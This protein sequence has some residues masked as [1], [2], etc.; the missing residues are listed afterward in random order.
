MWTH[1]DVLSY[2]RL[3]DKILWSNEREFQ[4]SITQ[5]QTV[6]LECLQ[7]YASQSTRYIHIGDLVNNDILWY[8]RAKCSNLKY[9]KLTKV[10][11]TK[12]PHAT[13]CSLPRNLQIIC[14]RLLTFHGKERSNVIVSSHLQDFVVEPFLLLRHLCLDGAHIS[15]EFCEQLCISEELTTL[16]L[17]SCV[18]D[19]NTTDAFDNLTRTLKKLKRVDLAF[20]NF[21]DTYILEQILRSIALNLTNCEQYSFHCLQRANG[22]KFDEFLRLVSTNRSLRGLKLSAIQGITPDVF[23]DFL[24]QNPDIESLHLRFCRTVND[25]T[26]RSVVKHLRHLKELKLSGC[27][28]ITKNGIRALAHHPYLE[29]LEIAEM[30]IALETILFV[31]R[32]LP[33]INQLV[34]SAHAC[35]VCT[36]VFRREKPNLNIVLATLDYQEYLEHFNIQTAP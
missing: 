3:S 11:S 30:D 4:Q 9:I 26:L 18:F 27:R 13:L 36:K 22:V 21:L 34:L 10:V 19:A 31:V 14:L 35:K 33:S 17:Q 6:A 28:D 29:V 7:T 20:C 32:L 24:R 5:H 8:I 15:S 12:F 25:E 23:D 2:K 1:I 16:K